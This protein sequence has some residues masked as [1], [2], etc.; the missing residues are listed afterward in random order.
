M[1][2]R[3][4]ELLLNNM[5]YISNKPNISGPTT[6]AHSIA[7]GRMKISVVKEKKRRLKKHIKKY[8]KGR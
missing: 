8:L 1:E 3:D 4:G 5:N 2:E 6:T 7:D